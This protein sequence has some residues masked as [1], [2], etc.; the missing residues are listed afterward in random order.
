MSVH[1]AHLC[2]S[3]MV[4]ISFTFN[5]IF[6]FY[7]LF[8][9]YIFNLQ[10]WGTIKYFT[11]SLHSFLVYFQSQSTNF[12]HLCLLHHHHFIIFTEDRI[13][14]QIVKATVSRIF[15]PDRKSTTKKPKQ[16]KLAATLMTSPNQW[17]IQW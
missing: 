12:L 6:L 7:E 2:K 14:R 1:L 5:K 3:T 16:L 8:F 10:H 11:V 4:Y 15:I 9:A 17:Y 13:K